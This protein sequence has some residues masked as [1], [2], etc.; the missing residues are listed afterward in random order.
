MN[1]TWLKLPED[2]FSSDVALCHF[3]V[4]LDFGGGGGFRQDYFT[5]FEPSQSLGG[6]KTG[7][8]Q[9]KTPD[10]LQAELGLSHI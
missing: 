8:P 2:M 3:M 1:V 9:E 7:D 4:P 5:H 10:H 6:A